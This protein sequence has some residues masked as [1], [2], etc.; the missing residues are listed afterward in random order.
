MH[1]VPWQ[2]DV[3]QGL[4]HAS[5]VVGC[6]HDSLRDGKC[7]ASLGEY[8]CTAAGGHKCPLMWCVEVGAPRPLQA[9]FTQGLHVRHNKQL[10]EGAPVME[11]G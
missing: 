4:C 8:L 2:L 3:P 6:W 10:C 7:G 1:A 11:Y 9:A 5:E